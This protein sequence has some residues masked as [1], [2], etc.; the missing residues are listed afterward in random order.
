M[1]ENLYKDSIFKYKGT[2]NLYKI[3]SSDCKM[4][5]PITREWIP[6]V[7]YQSCDETKRIW[8]RE[9]QEF[10]EKFELWN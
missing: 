4:K 8:I 7:I 9:L 2:G 3:L 10:K 1:M 5:H 6:A